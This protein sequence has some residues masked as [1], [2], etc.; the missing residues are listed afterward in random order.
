MIIVTGAAGFI[1]SCLVSKLNQAG[2]HN[3]VVVDDFTKHEKDNNLEG[4]IFEAKVERALFGDW[5]ATNQQKIDIIFHIGARTDT[6]EFDKAIFDALNVEYTQMLWNFCA[7][8]SIPLVYASSAATYGLGEFGYE[9]NHDVIT[10]LKPLNPYGDSKND[11]D[12][13]ALQQEKF[14]HHFGQD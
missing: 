1:G 10:K 3:I 13:W 7:D 5:L 9:D 8:H 12:I 4:K 11:F 6:T 2:F 14:N